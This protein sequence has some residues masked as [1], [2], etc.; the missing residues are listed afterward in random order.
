MEDVK[1]RALASSPVNPSFQK[2]Y[3]D[4][5]ASAVNESKIDILLQSY[6]QVPILLLA[7]P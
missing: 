2:R 3:V 4:D 5:V 1:Q 7:P 6:G